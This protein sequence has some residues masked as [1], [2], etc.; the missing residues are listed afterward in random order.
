MFAIIPIIGF[1]ETSYLK[2]LTGTVQ[3]EGEPMYEMVF[4]GFVQMPMDLLHT[5]G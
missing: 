3:E 5:F 2:D 1:F 4:P